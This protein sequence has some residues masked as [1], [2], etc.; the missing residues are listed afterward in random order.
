MRFKVDSV[1]MLLK[2]EMAELEANEFDLSLT[3]FD[4]PEIEALL[5]PPEADDEADVPTPEPP[6]DPVSRSGDTMT[7]SEDWR[8]GQ[9]VHRNVVRQCCG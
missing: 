2:L 5:K 3:G 6:K 8:I 9:S 7:Q 4:A 1:V